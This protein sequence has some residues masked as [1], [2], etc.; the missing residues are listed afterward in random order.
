MNNLSIMLF[1]FAAIAFG[2]IGQGWVSLLEHQRRRQTL[3]VI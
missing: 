1:I 2:M 3:D